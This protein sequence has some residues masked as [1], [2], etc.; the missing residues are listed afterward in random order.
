MAEVVDNQVFT[1]VIRRSNE[2]PA[3]IQSRHPVYKEIGII[4]AGQHKG[5]YIDARQSAF[6]YLTSRIVMSK[7]RR[8]VGT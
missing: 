3:V 6:F 7:Q 4:I 5:I 1:Q 8:L 2:H